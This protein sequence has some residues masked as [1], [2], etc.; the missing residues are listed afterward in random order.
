M[1]YV[2]WLT[3]TH[4]ATEAAYA[5]AKSLN[6]IGVSARIASSSV[7]AD[8]PFRLK[9]ELALLMSQPQMEPL[10]R[11]FIMTGDKPDDAR[12]M[13]LHRSGPAK[14]GPHV[15]SGQFLTR[16]AEIT[17][18]SRIGYIL[19]SE[20]E[21]FRLPATGSE[22]LASHYGPVFGVEHPHSLSTDGPLKVLL[23][24]PDLSSSGGASGLRA[25]C[26]SRKLKVT[27]LTDSKSKAALRSAGLPM[28]V[29]HYSEA[30]L[31]DFAAR[32]DV[33]VFCQAVPQ[34]YSVRMMLADL[35]VS[36]C[37]LLD[38][39]PGFA[40]RRLEP[41]FVPAPSDPVSLAHFIAHEI[42]PDAGDMAQLSKGSMLAARS[43]ETVAKLRTALLAP[44]ATAKKTTYQPKSG[45]TAQRKEQ[46]VFLPTNGVGLGHAQRCSIIASEFSQTPVK[47]VFAAFPSCMR[48][49]KTY[50]FD[51]MPL[52]QKS[53][54]HFDGLANDVINYR[55]L[56]RLL[57]DAEV[58]I[59]D[60][61]YVFDSC[62]RTLLERRVPSIW[63]RRGLWQDG[64]DN[65]VALDREKI[66]D[67]VIVPQEAF[68]ELNI[69]YS[70]GKNTVNVGPIVQQPLLTALDRNTL[71]AELADH[72]AIP[73]RQ[74]VVTM[75]GGGVAADRSSQ[76]IAAAASLARR[77]DVL[78]LVVVWPTANID[79]AL[80]GWPNTRIVRTH[81][82]SVLAT[83]ADLYISAVGYNS[84]HEAMYN[85]IPTIFIP[86]MAAYMDDQRARAAAAVE[87]G[88]AH[89]VEPH[90]LMLLDRTVT[91]M[92]EG[93]NEEMRMRLAAAE[94]PTPGMATAA[95]T[96]RALAG[97]ASP[98]PQRELKMRIA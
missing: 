77:R 39:S 91:R 87:R 43:R 75:L 7:P 5:F 30:P 95:A 4:A 69:D 98:T 53:T 97:I 92:L 85:Q 11:M 88:L 78:H 32:H 83:V 45:S 40:N 63:I 70:I 84:F 82:A 71:R 2:E 96:I 31:A 26:S 38:A 28:P 24:G 57:S 41:A 55:R 68:A 13:G 1:I 42:L 52:V 44:E 73:F 33:A 6:M 20:P 16:Q 3:A 21:V 29:Y 49:I 67:R 66:F 37:G 46:I 27:L 93:E 8:V 23:I 90:Q 17:A 19:G 9:Y 62:F 35:V 81:H 86:Q 94:L 36:G 50:G 48:L 51:V 61:G 76:T 58:F 47:P 12:L 80:F 64:Q 14:E 74:L 89:L 60:G 56:H 72:F 65:S 59:F 22:L 79:P 18:R 54:M 10:D 34:M 25:L 15:V